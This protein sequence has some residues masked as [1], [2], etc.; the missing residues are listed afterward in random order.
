MASRELF[1]GMPVRFLKSRTQ[2]QEERK[3][4]ASVFILLTAAD[5]GE[6]RAAEEGIGVMALEG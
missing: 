5:P 3:T 1:Q 4:F 2:A 6:S